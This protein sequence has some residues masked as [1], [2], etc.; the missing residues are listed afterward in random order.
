MGEYANIKQKKFSRLLKWLSNHKAIEILQGGR[1]VFKAYSIKSN[2]SF[3]LPVSHKIINK[4]IVKAFRDW[5][6]E[7]DICSIDEF[8]NHVK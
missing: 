5:L 3:P 7:N 1:H 6:V 4:H 2:N 8:D